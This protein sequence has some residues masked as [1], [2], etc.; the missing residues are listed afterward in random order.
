MHNLLDQVIAEQGSEKVELALNSVIQDS[1]MN[2]LT[3]IANQGD[4]S[5]PARYL[6]GEIF[7]ASKGNLDFTSGLI[8]K[9][10]FMQILKKLREKLQEKS[11]NR[12]YLIP[13]G[14]PTLSIQLKLSVYRIV[15]INT[16]DIFYYGGRYYDLDIDIRKIDNDLKRLRKVSP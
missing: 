10:Q 13:T 8:I 6:R 16:T 5:I 3:I 15:R 1:R 9:R 12:I 11:W 7:V 14:H 4:H 2:V